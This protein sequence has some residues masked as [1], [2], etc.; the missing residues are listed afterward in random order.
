MEIDDYFF[1]LVKKQMKKGLQCI[2][3]SLPMENDAHF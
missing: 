1:N 2:S 3:A